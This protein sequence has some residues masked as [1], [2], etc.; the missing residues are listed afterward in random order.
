MKYPIQGLILDVDG[1]IVGEKFGFNAPLPHPK[2][3]QALRTVRNNGFPVCLITSKPYFSIEKIVRGAGLNNPHVTDGGSVVIDPIDNVIIEKHVIGKDMVYEALDLF[4]KNRV[5]LEVYTADNYYAQKSQNSYITE[6]HARI[7][8]QAPI[9]VESLPAEAAKIDVTKIMAIAKNVVD[10]KNVE[11]VFKPLANKLS[12]YWAV[13][14]AVL[15]LQFG[16]V[17]PFGVSK[18]EGIIKIVKSLRL[19]F[20]TL[21]GVGD[22]ASDWQFMQLCQYGAAMGNASRELKDLV[23][24]KGA[25]FSFIAPSVDENGI[26]KVLEHFALI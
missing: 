10:I 23:Q 22:S 24:S 11:Q 19:S 6:Q 26:L 17:T 14:P 20:D 2:V 1:V 8:E 12:L 5:Y 9:V 16:I 13:H 7:L 25:E 18:T 21:L 15:P 4:L 3:I